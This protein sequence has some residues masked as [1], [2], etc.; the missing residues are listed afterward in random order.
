MTTG[1][2]YTQL[3]DPFSYYGGI[4]SKILRIFGYSCITL[5]QIDIRKYFAP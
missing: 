5:S 3:A 1:K 4:I 2:T